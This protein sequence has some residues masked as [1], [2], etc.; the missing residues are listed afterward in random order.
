MATL[1][2]TYAYS[3]DS[4]IYLTPATVTATAAQNVGARRLIRIVS[5]QAI[6]VKFGP[7]NSVVAPTATTGNRIPPNFPV[8][9][10]T[11]DGQSWLIIFNPSVS[12][13]NICISFLAKA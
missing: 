13:A 4:S 2:G 1:T 3:D 6:N 7:A 11:T 8:D 12:T 5:D 9:F 10:E